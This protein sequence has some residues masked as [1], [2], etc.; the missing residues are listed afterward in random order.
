[1]K[2]FPLFARVGQIERRTRTDVVYLPNL[3]VI[4]PRHAGLE[5]RRHVNLKPEPRTAK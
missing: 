1:M 3:A 5:Q 2:T 4:L